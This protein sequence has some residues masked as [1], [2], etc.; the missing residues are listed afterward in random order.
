MHETVTVIPG[1]RLGLVLACALAAQAAS[2]SPAIL[3]ATP[4][5][6][7]PPYAQD[8]GNNRHARRRAAALAR[9]GRG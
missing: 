6:P 1:R 2:L 7:P 5:V 4:E 8:G 3:P 9:G